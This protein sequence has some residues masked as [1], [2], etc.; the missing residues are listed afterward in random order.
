VEEEVR[1]FVEWIRSGKIEVRINIVNSFVRRKIRGILESKDVLK[2]FDSC[3][4]CSVKNI[5]EVRRNFLSSIKFR[6]C[7]SLVMYGFKHE[8]IDKKDN[9]IY[10]LKELGFRYNFRYNRRNK[11]RNYQI[12]SKIKINK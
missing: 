10:Y 4:F 9:F 2:T 8:R 7:D 6:R 5:G 12:K 1:K 3:L 11:L